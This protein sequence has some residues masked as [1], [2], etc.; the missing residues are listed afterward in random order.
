[1]QEVCVLTDQG[2]YDLTVGHGLERIGLL[3]LLAQRSVVVNLAI[4]GKNERF[5]LVGERLG[6]ALNADNAQSLMGKDSRLGYDI[7]TPVWAAMSG[8][9]RLINCCSQNRMP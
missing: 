1:M 3:E 9:I 5:V 8:A 4:D 6:T 7:S 2:Y